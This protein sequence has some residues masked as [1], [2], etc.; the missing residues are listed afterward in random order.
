[1]RHIIY[2]HESFKD[3][4]PTIYEALES[5]EKLLIVYNTVKE[6]QLVFQ[7]LNDLFPGIRSMLIHSRFR[8]RDRRERE[9]RLMS[10]FDAGHGPCFVVST[11]V[12]EVSLDISFDRM[13]TQAAPLDSLIQRFGRVNRER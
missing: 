8:R 12:V 5:K 1:D 6:A 9:H 13:I 3:L 2:K 11:Q 10:E 7:Q 4:Y